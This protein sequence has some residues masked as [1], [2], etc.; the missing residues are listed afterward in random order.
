MRNEQGVF[1]KRSKTFLK[2]SAG[3]VFRKILASKLYG[4]LSFVLAIAVQRIVKYV[5][6]CTKREVSS[7]GGTVLKAANS[8]TN[9]G[10]LNRQDKAAPPSLLSKGLTPS[11]ETLFKKTEGGHPNFSVKHFVK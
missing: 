3:F 1:L 11:Q 7:R 9:I 4:E 5:H 2:S 8:F 6:A 10:T